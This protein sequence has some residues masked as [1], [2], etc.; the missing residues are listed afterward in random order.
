MRNKN[1]IPTQKSLLKGQG[2]SLVEIALVLPIVL[3]LFLGLAEVGFF[4][5]SHVQVANAAREGAR[6]GSLCNMNGN[7]ADSKGDPDLNELT[8]AVTQRVEDEAPTLLEP[9]N[10][11]V[12]VAWTGDSTLGSPITVTVTYNHTAPFVSG[13][14]PMFPSEIPITHQAIMLFTR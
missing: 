10:T 13:F 2:Q 7:C 4:L 6:Y 9:A 1:L 8:T 5:Y 14:V 11:T 3:I 12:D